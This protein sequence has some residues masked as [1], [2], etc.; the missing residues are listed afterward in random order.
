MDKFSRIV[1]LFLQTIGRR[2]F[3]ALVSRPPPETSDA[4]GVF[5]TVIV[6]RPSRDDSQQRSDFEAVRRDLRARRQ[7]KIAGFDV[8]PATL[9]IAVLGLQIAF[10]VFNRSFG[11]LLF[12]V[13]PVLFFGAVFA[14]MTWWRTIRLDAPEEA[15]AGAW[16][17][18]GCCPHCAYRLPPRDSALALQRLRCTECGCNWRTLHTQQEPR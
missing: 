16:L 10:A 3:V 14:A 13:P 2:L 12:L 7:L 17:R 11:S 8:V 6:R 1:H 4:D 18:Q 5:R 9:F 15:I